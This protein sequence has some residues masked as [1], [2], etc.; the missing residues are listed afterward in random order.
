[1]TYGAETLVP[2]EHLERKLGSYEHAMEKRMIGAM[3][4]GRKRVS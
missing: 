3:L 1:M 4:R 2:T